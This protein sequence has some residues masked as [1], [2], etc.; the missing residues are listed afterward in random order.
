M[1]RYNSTTLQ[2]NNKI[3][4]T[5]CRFTGL[6][7]NG[8]VKLGYRGIFFNNEK[9]ETTRKNCMEAALTASMRRTSHAIFSGHFVS[10]VVKKY[11][12]H[13]VTDALRLKRFVTVPVASMTIATGTVT[14]LFKPASCTLT[15]LLL[16]F[17]FVCQCL[18]DF[19]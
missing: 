12:C 2:K 7:S 13:P 17:Q 1:F 18:V 8:S 16:V 3:S 4:L 15:Y 10:F 9:H 14:P 6:K 11:H 19:I 5:G